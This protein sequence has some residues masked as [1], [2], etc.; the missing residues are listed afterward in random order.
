MFTQRRELLSWRHS[1][2]QQKLNFRRV[3]LRAD[4]YFLAFLAHLLE[5]LLPLED[6]FHLLVSSSCAEV[7]VNRDFKLGDVAIFEDVSQSEHRTHDTTTA[8]SG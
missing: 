2:V 7:V 6:H 4:N 1:L 3:A 5:L 8:S